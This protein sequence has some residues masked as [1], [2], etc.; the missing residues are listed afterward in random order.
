MAPYAAWL[1]TQT[2]AV[3]GHKS[4]ML[5]PLADASGALCQTR[6]ARPSPKHRPA[7]GPTC[8]AVSQT[9]AS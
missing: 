4:G 8:P 5:D 6:V 7:D 9:W 3:A 2:S 1:L